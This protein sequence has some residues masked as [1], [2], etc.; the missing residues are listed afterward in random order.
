MGRRVR[1]VWWRFLRRSSLRGLGVIQS[2]RNTKHKLMRNWLL[3]GR[4]S[5]SSLNPI[6]PLLRLGFVSCVRSV[7]NF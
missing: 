6:R 3:G 4:R 1:P 5:G 2:F 7:P